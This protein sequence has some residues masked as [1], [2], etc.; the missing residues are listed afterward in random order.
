MKKHVFWMPITAI[1]LGSCSSRT[2]LPPHLKFDEAVSKYGQPLHV[3]RLSDGG[4]IA[5][6]QRKVPPA[7]ITSYT[8]TFDAGGLCIDPKVETKTNGSAA[9][10][11]L[12]E[13][14]KLRN[15]CYS[16]TFDPH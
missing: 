7:S 9:S 10:E 1:L 14:T 12:D 5:A 11:D 3:D 8:L 6:F 15:V 4:S 13:L 2:P 16:H